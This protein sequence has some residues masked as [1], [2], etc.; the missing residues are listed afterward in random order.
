MDRGDWWR[1]VLLW[2][3]GSDLRLTLLAVPPVLPLIHADLQLDEKGIAALSGL[4]ILLLGLAAVPGSL[5]IARVGPRR[6]LIFGLCIIGISSALRGVGPSIVVLF[7][8]T[9]CMGAGI[10]I[11]QPTF[12]ALV[13]SWFP[14]A[15][16]R[17]TGF[18][19][20]GLLVGELIGAALTL[21]VVLP[22]VGSWEASFA[23]WAVPV[24]LTAALF[25]FTTSRDASGGTT[26]LRPRGMP[27]WTNGR[28]WRLGLLQSSA[29]MIYFGANT[30][31]PDY[32]HATGQ[33][34]QV[35]LALASLNG[36]QLPASAVIGLA[37]L[38]VLA[39]PLISYAVAGAILVSLVVVLTLPGLPLVLA[40][41]MFGFC[42]AYVLVLT[43]ALPALLAE[44]GEVARVSAG[45]FAISYSTSFI[46]T[47]V[48]GA[49]WDASHVEASAFLPALAGSAIVATLGPGLV[50]AASG[51]G[52]GQQVLTADAA[53]NYPERQRERRGGQV[54]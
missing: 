20:N 4:P 40:A 47:L 44:P 11:C 19:S 42:A 45:T 32:L 51:S 50:S 1:L 46:T 37:P 41:G 33:S 22:L 5:L 8:M 3:A 18:W 17:A 48:A 13:R 28:M 35:G 34:D 39:R 36:L 30:F 15:I 24:L 10:S 7:G 54:G 9:L 27:D 16:T 2:L 53:E 26:V 43:F 6:A 23:V 38:S 25:T 29:S 12:P 31:I 52:R 21:P 14:R 49:I